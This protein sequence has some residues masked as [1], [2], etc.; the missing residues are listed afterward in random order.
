MAPPIPLKLPARDP[1]AELHA[2]LQEAPAEHAE[3]ILAGYE[4]LQG[5][6][7]RGV[8]DLVRG[9][10]G[11]GDKVIEIAVEA[12]QSPQSIRGLRNLLLLINMLGEIEP[13][14]LVK[15]TRAVPQAMQATARQLEQP[16]IWKPMHD[17]FLNRDA[18]RG[19]M[20]FISILEAFGANLA[21]K[22]DAKE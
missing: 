1:R 8:L 10:L 12:A 11:S 2:R 22:S 6:H 7:D 3:A 4:V 5:L 18:R 19:L 21:P 20:A 16:G 17:L 14:Q 9:A 13:Q 15:L